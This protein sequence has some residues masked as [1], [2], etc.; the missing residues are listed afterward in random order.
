MLRNWTVKASARNRYFVEIEISTRY[1]VFLVAILETR[2]LMDET[3]HARVA[4][5]VDD[6]PP[7]SSYEETTESRDPLG[8]DEDD[9]K[10]DGHDDSDS[11]VWTFSSVVLWYNHT[12]SI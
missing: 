9:E 11:A 5:A 6:A 10:E 1:Q 7:T 4:H 8:P 3:K 2:I 12:T